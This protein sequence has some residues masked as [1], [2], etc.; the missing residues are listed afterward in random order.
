[1][2]KRGSLGFSKSFVIILF[3]AIAIG[4]ATQNW[5]NSLVIIGVFA[6]IKIIWNI[7]T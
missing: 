2:N 4:Y 5:H 6:I 1:M 3:V 7:L